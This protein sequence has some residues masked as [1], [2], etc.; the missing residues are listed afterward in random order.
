MVKKF[1][2]VIVGAGAAGYSAAIYAHRLGLKTVVIG[3]LLGGTL[4]L[5][6]LVENYPGFAS[7]SGYDLMQE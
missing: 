5:T 2:C 4:T 6:H 3:E 1:D 7:I